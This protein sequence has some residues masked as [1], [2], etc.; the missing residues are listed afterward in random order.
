MSSNVIQVPKSENNQ[1]D[2]NILMRT[3]SSNIKDNETNQILEK[4]EHINES[5]NLKN[6]I[7]NSKEKDNNDFYHDKDITED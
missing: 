6:E 5:T 3:D 4:E 7:N 2:D 1:Q